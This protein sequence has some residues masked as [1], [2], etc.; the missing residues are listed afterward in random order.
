MSREIKSAWGYAR[1]A[2]RRIACAL[3]RAGV[4]SKCY[5]C[6][7]RFLYRAGHKVPHE[8]QHKNGN[9]FDN[10][11]RNLAV[12]CPRCHSELH[13]FTLQTYLLT[14]WARLEMRIADE[15]RTYVTKSGSFFV[16]APP[17]RAHP[18]RPARFI[19]LTQALRIWA[20]AT[21]PGQRALRRSNAGNSSAAYWFET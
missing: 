8:W 5:V 19:R 1:T 10:R 14:S 9:P 12:L 6:Q 17:D 21:L 16:K 15:G 2:R 18:K 3:E 20:R 7:T 13:V 4:P 11:K